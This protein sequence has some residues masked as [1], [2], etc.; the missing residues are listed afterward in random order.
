MT[1]FVWLDL[2]TTGLD[3]NNCQIIEVGVII[4]NEKF[5][6]LETYEAVVNPGRV[7]YEDG[8]IGFHKKS[9]LFDEVAGGK[10][11]GDV[12]EELL[13]LIMRYE[14]TKKRAYLAGNSVHFDR[15]FLTKYMPTVIEHL[16][17]RHLDISVIG[18]L[19]K[20]LFA[21]EE[22]EYRAPRPHRALPDL[23]RSMDELKFYLDEF[24]FPKNI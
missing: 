17:S 14:P 2:E 15:T 13:A 4:S 16:T 5:E 7:S 24:I 23:N 8:A 10:S 6:K 22:S 18:V 20:A 11:L 1:I 19:M 21:K 9:G 12:E 3:V